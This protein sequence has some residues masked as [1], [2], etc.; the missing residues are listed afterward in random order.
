MVIPW[1]DHVGDAGRKN[2]LSSTEIIPI[3]TGVRIS[4]GNL[5]T[6]RYSLGMLAVSGRFPRQYHGSTIAVSW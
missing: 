3:T 1:Q 4:E 6:A 5:N 2:Y